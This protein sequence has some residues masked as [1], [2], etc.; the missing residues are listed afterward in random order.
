M[1]NKQDAVVR[2]PY[3]GI[4][5]E[6][7]N[8]CELVQI[9]N[10]AVFYVQSIAFAKDGN[11]NVICD[12]DAGDQ[13]TCSTSGSHPRRKANFNFQWN[14]SIISSMADD[15]M[16]EDMMEIQNFR[17]HPFPEALNRVLFTDPSA[18]MADTMDPAETRYGQQFRS[19]HAGTLPVW[20]KD[21]FY[22][23]IRPLIQA[24]ADHNAEILFVDFLTVLHKHWPTASS[25]PTHQFNLPDQ[26]GYVWGSGAM[27]Y[28][29]MMVAILDRRTTAPARGNILDAL[30][31]TAPVL[32]AVVINGKSM[33]R[34]A[35]DAARYLFTPRTGLAD[36]TGATSSAT[37]EGTPIPT[38]SPYQILADA[39]ALKKARLVDAAQEGEAW[40]RAT[41]NLVDVL[42]RADPV[43]TVGWRF[44]NPRTRG[45][46]VALVDFLQSRI[47]AHR[48]A[49]DLDLWLTGD[50]P[51]R[52]EDALAGPVFAGAADFVLS[53]QAS[54]EAR[55]QIEALA[56]YLV[57]EVNYNES[58]RASL[59]AIADT[60]QLAI[61]DAD[62]VPIAR[63][64]GQAIR[65]DRGWLDSHLE[66]G[67]RARAGDTG[68]ALVDLMHNLYVEHRPG[69]T[70]VGDLIDG[71]SE[72]HRARPYEDLGLWYSGDDYRAM[73]TGIA[74]FLDDNK[75]G[76]RRFISIIQERNLR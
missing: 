11:G 15:Q 36:R 4:P 56:A 49:G 57:N 75:R 22:D 60:L 2:D 33:P 62:I 38:L 59:S 9:D 50:L 17:A 7:Y 65:L 64:A 12:N 28:E 67:K 35:A 46:M 20:E 71:I 68:E 29:P 10:L 41:G 69:H 74:S 23:Q 44:R 13:V 48:T 30:V 39:Y 58:F 47:A 55:A 53:L 14:N 24:F 76:L 37:S 26:A 8:E 21:G 73:F 51:A 32:D 54:P 63:F 61:D 45:V 18:A 6:Y 5:L 31:S 16:L 43:P 52:I 42:L 1:C 72:V 25:A 19:V 34:V 70:A 3:L 66:F 40:Q 27:T